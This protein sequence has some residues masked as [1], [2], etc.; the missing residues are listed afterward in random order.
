[1]KKDVISIKRRGNLVGTNNLRYLL[2]VCINIALIVILVNSSYSSEF[3][4]IPGEAIRELEFVA[5]TKNENRP[6]H[7]SQWLI[8][9]NMEKLGFKIKFSPMT[10]EGMLNKVWHDHNYDL[11]SL[12]Y[13]GRVHRV[14]P[15]EL[16]TKSYHSGY[17]EPTNYNF[18]H[19][20]D[21][22]IEKV[23]DAAAIEVDIKKRR[24]MVFKAQEMIMAAPGGEIPFVH[25]LVFSAYNSGNFKGFVEMAGVGLKNVWTFTEVEA[26]TEDKTLVCTTPFEPTHLTPFLL[27]TVNLIAMRGIYDTLVK[28]GPDGLP[29]PWLATEWKWI[30]NKSVEF[31]IRQGHKFHDGK[32][33]TTKDI[34]FSY[35]YVKRWKIPAFKAGA[36]Y[37]DSVEILSD[38][39]LRINLTEPFA[40]IFSLAFSRIF[41]VPE[42][43]WKDIPEKVDAEVPWLYSPL[44]D[45][46]LIGSGPLKFDYWKKGI[47]VKQSSYKGHWRAPKYESRILKPVPNPEALLGHLKRGEIDFVIEFGGEPDVL[48][49]FCKKDPNYKFLTTVSIGYYE[50]DMLCSRAPFDDPVVRKAIAAVI[51]KA[52]I[53]NEIYSGYA[54]PALSPVSPTLKYWHN[55][56]VT[57]WEELGIEGAKKLLK[58]AG[59]WWDSKGRLHYP[60]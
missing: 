39:K 33:L 48:E 1:M 27:E 53:V 54:V 2:I 41:I 22:E 58:D 7:D 34:K 6:I 4:R 47:E 11:A 14:D 31:E 24:E 51:P 12:G 10:R 18:S 50:L 35:D 36:E 21:P 30:G 44:K 56:N 60:K 57:K 59:Y 38:K 8:A 37:I 15:Y 5:F 16:L 28:V 25:P 45:G 43:I 55:P 42:H 13:S 23:L 29:K 20:S 32:P 26:L 3:K 17:M 19:F 49:A 52:T 46:N 40:P 9:E